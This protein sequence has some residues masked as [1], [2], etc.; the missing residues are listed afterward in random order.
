MGGEAVVDEVAKAG[1]VAAEGEAAGGEVAD[2]KARVD[3]ES[4]MRRKEKP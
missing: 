1:G 4:K 2:G 3:G